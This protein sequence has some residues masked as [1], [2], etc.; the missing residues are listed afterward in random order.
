MKRSIL[1]PIMISMTK[2]YHNSIIASFLTYIT[3]RTGKLITSLVFAGMALCIVSCEEDPT[4]IGSGIL[5]GKDFVTILSTD[6]ISV[7]SFTQYDPASRSENKEYGLLGSVYNP[8]FGVTTAELVSQLRLGSKWT[9]SSFVVDSVKLILRFE[10]VQGDPSAVQELTISEISEQLFNNVPYYSNTEVLL[11]GYDVGT[12]TIP[13]LKDTISTVKFNLPVSFGEY[14]LRD[15]TMLFHSN[16][17]DD[18]RTYFKGL[19]FRITSSSSHRMLTLNLVRSS[20]S[21]EFYN[22]FVIYYHTET[23]EAEPFYLILD[24]KNP[25]A[26]FNRYV[27]DFEAS[28]PEKRIDHINDGYIDTLSYVQALN[29]AYTKIVLPGLEEI[30]NNQELANIAVNKAHLTIPVYKD[31]EVLTNKTTARKIYLTYKLRDTVYYVPDYKISSDFF[32]GSLDTVK[33]VY[34]FNIVSYIQ[35]YLQDENNE[36]KPELE[37]MIA[38]G[39][40][41]NAVLKA[42]GSVTPIK[43]ILT[44]TKF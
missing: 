9:E 6:T 21:S 44:Y 12:F 13:P 36:L 1:M 18:F 26:R 37:M 40:E 33:G 20:T 24:A 14:I 31:N 5:P 30:K 39:P 43:F 41:K 23:S 42:N 17:R 38:E 11:T 25:N 27:H 32:D 2:Y 10:D 3:H 4:S 29:G 22:Y 19:Y 7:Y 34:N 15:T 16:A 28:D 35:N 8:Y